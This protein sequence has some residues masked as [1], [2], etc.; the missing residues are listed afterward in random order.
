MILIWGQVVRFFCSCEKNLAAFL[1]ISPSVGSWGKSRKKIWRI[2]ADRSHNW[3]Q[4]VTIFFLQH[5]PPQICQ[6]ILA[7]TQIGFFPFNFH[8]RVG[9]SN[10]KS[11]LKNISSENRWSAVYPHTTYSRCLYRKPTFKVNPGLLIQF[12]QTKQ[13]K[14]KKI[15][16]RKKSW[17]YLL[18]M[19]TWLT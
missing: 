14:D 11:G 4:S 12:S 2:F 16:Q 15:I 3:L 8:T 19:L 10:L 17:A 18:N 7:F 13:T 5:H 6:I 1:I 9:N